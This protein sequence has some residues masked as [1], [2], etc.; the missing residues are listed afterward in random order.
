MQNETLRGYAPPLN[1]TQGQSTMINRFFVVSIE[2][3]PF[4]VPHG[5]AGPGQ[6]AVPSTPS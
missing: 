3:G 1:Y 4:A 2:K 5:A 6:P